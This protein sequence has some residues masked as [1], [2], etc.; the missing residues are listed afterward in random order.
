MENKE[1]MEIN[2]EEG[3]ASATLENLSDIWIDDNREE[4]IGLGIQNEEEAMEYFKDFLYNGEILKAK[5]VKDK[6]MNN[7]EEAN[8]ILLLE[9]R[10]ALSNG[11][12]Y[13]AINVKEEFGL[14]DSLLVDREI[15][16]VAKEGFKNALNKKDI[17]FAKIIKEVFSLKDSELLDI[18]KRVVDEM[19]EKGEDV[20]EINR[21]FLNEKTG[22]FN[23]VNK[24]NL[25]KDKKLFPEEVK[26][27]EEAINAFKHYLKQGNIIKSLKIKES[28]FPNK[29][30]EVE[31]IR[32]DAIQGVKAC[33]NAN[34]LS[35]AAYIKNS[36]S[37]EEGEI[38]SIVTEDYIRRLEKG[39]ILNALALKEIFKL[40]INN[41]EEIINAAAHGYSRSL[42]SKDIA[43]AKIIKETFLANE[44]NA[45]EVAREF[46]N[47]YILVG[48][49]DKAEE[50]KTAILD[51]GL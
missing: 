25:N 11:D 14:A 36:L 4:K 10:F 26:A 16:E 40:T 37:I 31:D 12:I 44:D 5:Q 8:R 3:I 34:E 50:I 43:S 20:E 47:Q 28:F 33:L 9:F 6:Y 1:E 49:N 15:R 22:I 19:L 30:L 24:S 48:E 21:H 17:S 39:D 13:R 2:K 51:S 7:N 42:L 35:R 46:Y 27:T 38:E 18:T 32:E 41:N 45:I 23:E 29:E